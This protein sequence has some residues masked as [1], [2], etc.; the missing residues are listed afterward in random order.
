MYKR[1]AYTWTPTAAE[2]AAEYAAT[3]NSNTAAAQA[4]VWCYHYGK[5]IGTA[6]AGGTATVDP[7][8]AAP[9]FSGFSFADTR[10]ETTALTGD[11]QVLVA[12]ESTLKVIVPAAQAAKSTTGA[13]IKQYILYCGGSTATGG[14]AASGDVLSL[15]HISSRYGFPEVNKE[16]YEP[17]TP[18]LYDIELN[19]GTKAVSYTHL[20]EER[21]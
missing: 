2:V 7:A 12:G 15:I 1:Q 11:D 9:I 8:A 14:Y 16:E 4:T 6:T 3:P 5:L 20:K 10:T 17:I 18:E 21:K 13:S 19:A